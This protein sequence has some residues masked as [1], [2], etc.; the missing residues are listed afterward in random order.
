MV[1]AADDAQT[2][3]LRRHLLWRIH[4]RYRTRL[5]TLHI[6]HLSIDFTRIENPDVVLD[7]VAEEEDRREKLSGRR[8]DGDYLHLPYWAELWDSA[9]GLGQLL[10]REGSGFGVQGSVLD[11]GC[12]MGLAERWPRRWGR[13]CCWPTLRRRRCSLQRS[14][15]CRGEIVSA[16]GG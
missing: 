7:Q 16:P 1:S 8:L 13:M 10:A 9:L 11:L 6:G 15:A 4:R 5:E 3:R 12:G 14:I 2:H